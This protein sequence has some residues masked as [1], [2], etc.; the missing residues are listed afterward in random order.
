MLEIYNRNKNKSKQ[1]SR[2][3]EVAHVVLR[4]MTWG[5]VWSV[6]VTAPVS[7][8]ECHQCADK[9]SFIEYWI[10]DNQRSMTK[11]GA[12][13]YWGTALWKELEDQNYRGYD[14]EQ[15]DRITRAWKLKRKRFDIWIPMKLLRRNNPRTQ[16]QRS[17]RMP[18]SQV[19]KNQGTKVARVLV[20]N[21]PQII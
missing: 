1:Q 5:R 14:I 21:L 8:Q 12:V 17:W 7:T 18:V 11:H 6:W 13:T 20:K 9:N 16:R 15:L 3:R 2:R 10:R 19:L 4:G